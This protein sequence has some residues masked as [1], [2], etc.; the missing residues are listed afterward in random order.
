MRLTPAHFTL[1]NLTPRRDATISCVLQL[2]TTEAR[3]TSVLGLS[4]SPAAAKFKKQQLYRPMRR[5]A[6]LTPCWRLT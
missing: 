5:L 4:N 2:I 3:K 6:G 1:R